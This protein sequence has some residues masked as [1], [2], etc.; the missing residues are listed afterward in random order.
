MLLLLAFVFWLTVSL[1]LRP[2]G[3]MVVSG[4]GVNV[5][6]QSG[7]LAELGLSAIE[8]SEN[9]VDEKESSCYNNERIKRKSKYL[10]FGKE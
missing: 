7:L 2:S 8:G 9:T 10:F 4:V 5:N 6:V 1:V 3:E